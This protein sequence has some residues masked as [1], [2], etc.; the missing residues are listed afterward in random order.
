M[1][2]ERQEFFNIMDSFRKLNI[3][4]ML[5]EIS[6]GEFGILKMIECC[7]RHSQSGENGVKIS[8]IVKEMCVPPPAVSRA[9][10]SLESKAMVERKVDPSDR[11]NT[12]VML[13]AKG[14]ETLTEVENIMED[15]S[16]A[17]VGN[18]G[19]ETMQ[20]LNRYLRALLETSKTEIEKRKYTVVKGERE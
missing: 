9:L 7:S 14:R 1:R 5:P 16:D 12:F 3:S 15:F 19:D 20:K 4:S 8:Y 11:R 18:L 17:V 10:R 2:A 13:T 6:H